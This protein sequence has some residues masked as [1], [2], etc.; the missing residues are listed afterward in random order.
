[1]YI[2][3]SFLRGFT[4]IE[5]LVVVGQNEVSFFETNVNGLTDGIVVTPESGIWKY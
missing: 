2:Q 1:M 5:L 4:L 3:K